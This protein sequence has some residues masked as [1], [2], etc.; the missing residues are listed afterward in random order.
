MN[1]KMNNQGIISNEQVEMLE[2]VKNENPIINKTKLM[3]NNL[4]DPR[5]NKKTVISII[6]GLVLVVVIVL[7]ISLSNKYNLGGPK[8]N[9]D[10]TIAVDTGTKWGDVY[11]TFVQKE[12][13]EISPYDVALVDLDFNDTPEMLVKYKDV[14]N[15]DTLKIFYI[16]ED[17]VFST[18]Y[19]HLYSLHLLYSMKTK[20]VGWYIH[21]STNGDY[22]AYT[23]LA[24]M[25]NGETLDSDIKTNTEK[26]LE[27]FK[28]S[29]VDAKYKIVF[30]QI[31]NNSFEKD[32]KTV[33]SR[34]NEYEKSINAAIKK[35]KSDSESKEYVPEVD[36]KNYESL[37]TLAVKGR[38]IAFGTY[39]GN[40]T[41][42]VTGTVTE[43]YLVI[44]RDGT[45][46]Y[47]N[48]IY[49]FEID[50]SKIVFGDYTIDATA[51]NSFM[52]NEIFYTLY[53][54]EK[55]NLISN[56]ENTN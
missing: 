20:D 39:L 54:D 35:L 24:K 7:V 32:I 53:K 56:E 21:I 40:V 12:L 41:D 30:Y 52:C 27:T 47:N 11:A 44:S 3:M 51:N 28:K 43:S 37:E 5:K 29:Y 34:Y 2:P 33:I 46:M 55:G 8:V 4:K 31:N 42:K 9:E 25:I 6:G 50:Y 13:G 26:M 1:E 49:P 15:K 36:D 48:Q 38:K 19:F 17:E 23:N 10:G 45:I 22:G 14:S 18:K 16:V